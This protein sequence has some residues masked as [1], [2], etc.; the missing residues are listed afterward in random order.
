MKTGNITQ[1]YKYAL[2]FINYANSEIKPIVE[3]LYNQAKNENRI[4][5]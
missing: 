5:H 3:E 2:N 1:A 4:W